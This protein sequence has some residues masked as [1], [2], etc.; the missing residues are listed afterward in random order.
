MLSETSKTIV[1]IIIDQLEK[2]DIKG[3]NEDGVSI[4]DAEDVKYQWNLEAMAEMADALK[5]QQKEIEFLKQRNK[6]LR[7]KSWFEV[8]DEN[9]KLIDQVKSLKEQLRQSAEIADN[10]YINCVELEKENTHLK[11]VIESVQTFI[12]QFA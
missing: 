12:N 2:G 6:E 1:G 5:Y 8:Y 7:Q 4:D 3:K 10:F 11:G 9:L